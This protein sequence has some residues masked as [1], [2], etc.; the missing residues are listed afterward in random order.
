[1]PGGSGSGG[2]CCSHARIPR[3]PYLVL[4]YVNGLPPV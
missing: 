1:G 2:P 4:S 3:T